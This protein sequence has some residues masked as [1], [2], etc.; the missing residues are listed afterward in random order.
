MRRTPLWTVLWILIL[1]AL[2][3]SMY[4]L[5][6]S[7]QTIV[8]CL[9]CGGR[10]CR[11]PP[12]D[13]VPLLEVAR[14]PSPAFYESALNS[15][16]RLTDA[17]DDARSF[18]SPPQAKLLG[19][20]HLSQEPSLGA[21]LSTEQG[22]CWVVLRGSKFFLDWLYD[23][24]QNQVPCELGGMVHQG[25]D[26]VFQAIRLQ[27]RDK[28]PPGT[29]AVVL[30]GHSMGAAVATLLALDVRKARPEIQ[31]TLLTSACPRI[32]NQA[33]CAEVDRLVTRHVTL[34]N[35][36]DLIPT[37][38]AAVTSNFRNPF[39]PFLYERCGTTV[40]FSQNFKSTAENHFIKNYVI[41]WRSLLRKES[42][43]PS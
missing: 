10:E 35:D 9:Q 31:V 8:N 20:L 12:A 37:L 1:S 25:F 28:I 38:P 18:T 41:Y 16:L 24:R 29:K 26:T 17:V 34:R 4:A 23:A 27:T 33:F 19:T 14:F 3:W 30:T 2:L 40:L 21:V 6:V 22:E 39:E 15:I 43:A 13:D 32:G 7:E 11:A 42:D 5:L 36:A